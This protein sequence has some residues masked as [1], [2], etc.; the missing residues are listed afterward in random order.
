MVTKEDYCLLTILESLKMK[1]L[2]KL[3]VKQKYILSTINGYEL[4]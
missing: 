2:V 4:V 3:I 1:L